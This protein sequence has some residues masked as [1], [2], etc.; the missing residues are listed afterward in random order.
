MMTCGVGW[1]EYKLKK[2]KANIK[3]S[4]NLELVFN[5]KLGHNHEKKTWDLCKT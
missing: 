2:K 5:R 3:K 1:T 4:V